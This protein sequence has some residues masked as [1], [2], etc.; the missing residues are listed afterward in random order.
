M[1]CPLGVVLTMQES[2]AKVMLFMS[3]NVSVPFCCNIATNYT[4]DTTCNNG[5]VRLVGGTSELEG[6][7]EVCYNNYWGSVADGSWGTPDGNVACNRS[8][9]RPT[10]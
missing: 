8:G 6:S 1:Y 9:H 4:V 10:G 2:L 5:D 7:V 3:L